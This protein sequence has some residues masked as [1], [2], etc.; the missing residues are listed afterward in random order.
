MKII[1]IS[2]VVGL[3]LGGSALAS[4]MPALAKKQDCDVCHDIDKRV[5]GPA[6]MEVSSK[7]KGAAKYTY[8][9]KEY[10]LEDG[11]VM[12]VSRGGSGNWGSMPM[13]ANDPNGTKQAEIRELVNFVLGLAK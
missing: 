6:W 12:K 3:V 9:G 4:E 8:G 1:M 10:T 5:V 13:P 11:L 2:V 7:Y